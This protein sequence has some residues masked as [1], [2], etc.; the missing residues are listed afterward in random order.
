L[1]LSNRLKDRRPYLPR[2]ASRALSCD[3]IT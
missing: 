2:A 3:A 1:T